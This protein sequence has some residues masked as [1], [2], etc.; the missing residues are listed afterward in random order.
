MEVH[1]PTDKLTWLGKLLSAWVAQCSCQLC[2]LQAL[3]GFLQFTAQVIP[4]AHAFIHCL[5]EFSMTFSSKFTVCHILQ[6]TCVDI[7]WWHTF[8]SQWNGILI[9]SPSCPSMHVFMDTSG[10]ECKGISGVFGNAWFS[11]C[12]LRHFRKQDIQFKEL[13]TVMQATL[14]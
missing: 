4:H 7:H 6:Y 10:S 14:C 3:I 1:L 2:E 8:Y 11:S 5:I 12:M 9:I 13:F